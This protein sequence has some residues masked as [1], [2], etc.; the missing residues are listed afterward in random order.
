MALIDPHRLKSSVNN[1]L[2][3]VF[4]YRHYSWMSGMFSRSQ[5]SASW[6]LHH[7][8]NLCWFCCCAFVFFLPSAQ[9]KFPQ[10]SHSVSLWQLFI[11]YDCSLLPPLQN[12]ILVLCGVAT[13][14]SSKAF[15]K[16][17]SLQVVP[18]TSENETS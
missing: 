16:K 4:N 13:V 14:I 5:K 3:C 9:P 17:I 6:R 10:G 2:I 8:L 1:S 11:L 15:T 7:N 18:S 12:L